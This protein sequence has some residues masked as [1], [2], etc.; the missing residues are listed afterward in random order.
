MTRISPKDFLSFSG[1]MRTD[2][3][4]SGVELFAYALVFQFSQSSAGIY[5]GGSKYL[6]SWIGCSDNT[7]RK[8]L[9]SLVAR[10]YIIE[11]SGKVNG[12]PFCHY[13]SNLEVVPQ[14]LRGGTSNLEVGTSNFEDRD[15]IG[16][17]NG[18]IKIVE[19]EKRQASPR[20]VKPSV[21]EVREYCAA[22]GNSVDAEEFVD[23]YESKGWMIGKSPMKDWKAAVRTWEKSKNTAR[24]S[25]PRYNAPRQPE[26]IWEANRRAVEN[27]KR[28]YANMNADEQ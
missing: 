26:S 15:I 14:I 13:T 16:N 5:K 11:H 4:L 8:S 22:R 23:F 27:I 9:K 25:A 19:R 24:S 3:G 1:W 28:K 20:F 6:A 12:V 21:E 18:N 10:G 17:I 7:A 2:L